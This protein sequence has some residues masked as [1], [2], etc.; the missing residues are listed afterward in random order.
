MTLALM[1]L[2]CAKGKANQSA[3]G[4][5]YVG[6]VFVLMGEVISLYLTLKPAKGLWL[7]I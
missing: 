6:V 5:L 4:I 1:I 3:T 7:P 2:S